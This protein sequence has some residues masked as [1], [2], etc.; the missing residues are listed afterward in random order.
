MRLGDRHV[1]VISFM[2]VTVIAVRPGLSNCCFSPPLAERALLTYI[3][4]YL[5]ILSFSMHILW[6][7]HFKLYNGAYMEINN[8]YS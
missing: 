2:V 3:S 1:K 4:I 6:I 8:S 7:M 5:R